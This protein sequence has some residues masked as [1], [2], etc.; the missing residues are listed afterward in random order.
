[1]RQSTTPFKCRYPRWLPIA[2]FG[3]VLGV[4]PINETTTTANSAWAADDDTEVTKEQSAPENQMNGN[5]WI[6]QGDN[7]E[8]QIFGGG[9]G[10]NIDRDQVF[11][12]RLRL[13]I[14]RLDRIASLNA[15]Q[16]TRLKLGGE[17]DILRFREKLVAMKAR[18]KALENDPNAFNNV[19]QEIWP[20]Q[21]KFGQGLHEEGSLFRKTAARVL[22]TSQAASVKMARTESSA[23]QRDRKVRAAIVQVESQMNLI[24]TGTQRKWLSAR[25][26]TLVERMRQRGATQ[27]ESQVL[28]YL[29]AMIPEEELKPVFNAVQIKQFALMRQNWQGM[30]PWLIQQGAMPP[31]EIDATPASA[32]SIGNLH[33][34][35]GTG[36]AADSSTDGAT[37][38]SKEPVLKA[39]PVN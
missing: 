7:L 2:I 6:L 33:G 36:A 10:N 20:L 31:T 39:A 5:N 37:G 9:G 29:V 4:P 32:L 27:N 22:T 11:L 8:M 3:L 21:Q 26:A 25:V 16:K 23:R 19:W 15:E 35:S 17:G 12:A 14:R 18:F 30:E 13:E 34:G 1:M 38:V 24:L 28:F